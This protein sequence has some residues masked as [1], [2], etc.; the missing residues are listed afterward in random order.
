MTIE[1]KYAQTLFD[2]LNGWQDRTLERIGRRLK[3]TGRLSAYDQK[4][5]KNIANITGDMNAIYADLARVT[6]QNIK[7]VQT[8]L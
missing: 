3:A 8:A 5:L 6:G 2:N 4:A 1:E 7:E